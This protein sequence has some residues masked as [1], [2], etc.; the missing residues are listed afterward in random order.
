MNGTDTPDDRAL[1]RVANPAGP[2]DLDA[3]VRQ[4]SRAVFGAVTV[5]SEVALRSLAESMPARVAPADVAARTAPPG[6]LPVSPRAADALDLLLGLG[7]RTLTT[8]ETVVVRSTTI[9]GPVVRW[10]LAP[11]LVPEHLTPL[12]AMQRVTERWAGERTLAVRSFSD[13]SATLAPAVSDTAVR[14]VDVDALIAGVLDRLEIQQIADQVVAR[15]DLD[16]LIGTV[17]SGVDVGRLADRAMTDLDLTPIADQAL[18]QL[19]LD[20]VLARVFD[21]VDITQIVLDRVDLRRVIDSALAQLDLTQ[22][23]IDQVD[24]VRLTDY[25]VESVDLTELIRESTGS[26][27]SE[28]VYDI[29]LQ[30]VE[31]DQAVSRLIGR[32]LRRRTAQP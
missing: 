12:G 24:M 4:F 29:R 20:V 1:L 2:D 31:A 26:M 17:L 14:L 27:A 22:L 25:I 28:A 10:A 19:D 13:W 16:E 9:V 23:V 21:Q 7:W 15:L 5:A 32:V 6:S 30:G 3:T 11:P 18:Q 8:F